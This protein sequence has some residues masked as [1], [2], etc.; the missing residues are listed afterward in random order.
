MLF[1]YHLLLL[2]DKT[3]KSYIS[4]YRYKD[5]PDKVKEGEIIIE[6]EGDEIQRK[7][8]SDIIRSDLL[9]I[10]KIDLTIMERDSKKMRGERPFVFTNIRTGEGIKQVLQW[11]KKDVLLE[12]M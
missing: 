8:G 2:R 6:S 12:S 7:G 10:N 4:T 9:V 5:L 3:V 11:L 1:T